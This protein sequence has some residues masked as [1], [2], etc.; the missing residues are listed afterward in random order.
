MGKAYEEMFAF[1]CLCVSA[2]TWTSIPHPTNPNTVPEAAAVGP[3]AAAATAADPTALEPAAV[4]AETAAALL[5]CWAGAAPMSVCVLGG[6]AVCEGQKSSQSATSC[7]TDRKLSHLKDG[8]SYR[9]SLAR[10][11]DALGE[12]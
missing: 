9:R 6:G 2:P 10:R 1:V 5:G 3:S 11:V 12:V 7:N 4:A 8:Y